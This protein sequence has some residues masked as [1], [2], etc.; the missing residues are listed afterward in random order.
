MRVM[1]PTR[2]WAILVALSAAS[3]AIAVS[4]QA[5]TPAT[6]AIL[7]LAWAKARVILR[8]YLGLADAPGWSAGF[9]A[10]LAG[11]MLLAMGLAVVAA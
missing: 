8:H 2:A 11:F 7:V 5:G 3:T 6:L 10:A 9:S 1:A 4:G